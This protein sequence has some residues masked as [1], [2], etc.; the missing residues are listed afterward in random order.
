MK[1]AKLFKT[2]ERELF[3][4]LLEIAMAEATEDLERKFKS[5]KSK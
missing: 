3:N 2:D 4:L 1:I 5:R